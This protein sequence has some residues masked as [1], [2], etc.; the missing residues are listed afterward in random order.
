MTATSKR[1][2]SAIDIGT[3]IGSV[4]AV[5]IDGFKVPTFSRHKLEI[6]GMFGMHAHDNAQKCYQVPILMS[7]MRLLRYLLRFKRKISLRTAR[8]EQLNVC[9]KN[10]ILRCNL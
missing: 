3:K 9:T 1:N 2:K 10:V 8:N 6:T 5:P 4:L 7:F